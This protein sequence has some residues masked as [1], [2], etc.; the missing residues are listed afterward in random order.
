MV[1]AQ[2]LKKVESML[3][4]AKIKEMKKT[5]YRITIYLETKNNNPVKE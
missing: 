5:E 1:Q 2:F 3:T 4:F